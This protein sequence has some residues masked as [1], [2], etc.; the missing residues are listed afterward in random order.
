ML[1]EIISACDY[2][3]YIIDPDDYIAWELFAGDID[4]D[5]DHLREMLEYMTQI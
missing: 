4:M 3:E 1:L 5:T 2:F